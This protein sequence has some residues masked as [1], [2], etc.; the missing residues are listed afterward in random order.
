LIR[1]AG[2]SDHAAE[3]SLVAG[4]ESFDNLACPVFLPSTRERRKDAI[5]ER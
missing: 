5:P 2:G 3:E 1:I 4:A